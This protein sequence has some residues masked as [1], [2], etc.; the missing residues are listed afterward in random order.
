MLVGLWCFG[1]SA[2]SPYSTVCADGSATIVSDVAR[3]VGL[4]GGSEGVSGVVDGRGVVPEG[5]CSFVWAVDGGFSSD[6]ADGGATVVSDIARVVGLLG[7]STGDW[8]VAGTLGNRQ[9]G[10]SC[11]FWGLDGGSETF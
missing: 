3:V 6:C 1:F 2:D 4:L 11:F 5:A 10:V 8:G 7:V 9:G